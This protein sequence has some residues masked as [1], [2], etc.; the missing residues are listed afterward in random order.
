[1]ENS[2]MS[3][4]EKVMNMMTM[5]ILYIENIITKMEV[6]MTEKFLTN[7]YKVN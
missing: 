7:N 3:M 4:K 1:M 2:T 5:N 6:F